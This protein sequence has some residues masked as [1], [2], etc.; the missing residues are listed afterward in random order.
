MQIKDYV[1]KKSLHY[2]A[3]AQKVVLFRS[4]FLTPKKRN[5]VLPFEKILI[6]PDKCVD[7]DCLPLL[8]T[9]NDIILKSLGC[10]MHQSCIL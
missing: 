2:A 8:K 3:A 9:K 5:R 6:L 1:I 10:P 4:I 7:L